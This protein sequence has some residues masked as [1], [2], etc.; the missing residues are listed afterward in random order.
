MRKQSKENTGNGNY[1][2]HSSMLRAGPFQK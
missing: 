2:V 1:S